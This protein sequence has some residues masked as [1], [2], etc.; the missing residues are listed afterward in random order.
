MR[1]R[2]DDAM[3]KGDLSAV[4]W[5][6]EHYGKLPALKAINPSCVCAPV[7]S[8]PNMLRIGRNCFFA[9][10]LYGHPHIVQYLAQHTD[11]DTAATDHWHSSHD[12]VAKSSSLCTGPIELVL[13]VVC[14]LTSAVSQVGTL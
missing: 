7:G 4:V 1:G 10:C 11:V 3:Y 12:E 13:A 14:M 5:L 9:A 6:I 2:L 8:D